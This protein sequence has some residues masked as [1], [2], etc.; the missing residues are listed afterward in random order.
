MTVETILKYGTRI[1]IIFMVL[2]VHEFAHAYAAKKLGDRTAEN[3]GRLT[4][5]PISHIDPIG[6][7]CLLLAGFGWAK[8]VPI[9]P[10][11]FKHIKSG[12]II[13][14]LAGPLSNIIVAYIAL[15]I[16]KIVYYVAGGVLTQTLYYVLY[17][18][19]Y[20]VMIN[21]MLAVFNLIPIPPL[22]G[23]R[24]LTVFLPLKYQWKIQQYQMYISIG[25]MVLILFGVLNRPLNWLGNILYTC[26]EFLSR[27]VDLIF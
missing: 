11:R 1:L 2:P 16:Y 26:I 20:F 15:V 22:D 12:T 24:V 25:F 7:I 9:N 10:N 21:L 4:L 5:N 23:S 13:T 14:A 19:S 27:W 3:A 6:A 8:P 17:I 18:I